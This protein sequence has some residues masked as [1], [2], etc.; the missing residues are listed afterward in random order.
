[1]ESE[2]RESR[3]MSWGRNQKLIFRVSWRN[4]RQSLLSFVSLRS[5][6][7]LLISSL[8]CMCFLY[9]HFVWSNVT[10]FWYWL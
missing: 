10:F 1:M 5:L 4:S 2:Q 8:R 6:E 3:F 9:I 7:V